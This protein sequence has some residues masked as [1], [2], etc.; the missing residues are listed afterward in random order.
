MAAPAG[1]TGGPCGLV[2][3]LVC[4]D[5]LTIATDPEP[6]VTR[7]RSRCARLGPART[8]ARLN[9]LLPAAGDSN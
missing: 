3:A 6:R 2:K 8:S 5:Q 1:T 7:P 4:Q 9:G